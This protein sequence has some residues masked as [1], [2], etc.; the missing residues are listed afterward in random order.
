MLGA[1]VNEVDVD[2]VDLGDEVREG[3][4]AL[5][6]LSPVVIRCPIAGQRLDRLQLHA[7]GGIHFPVGPLRR[8]D[9]RTQVIELLFGDVDR[10]RADA[11]GLNGGAH[12]NLRSWWVDSALA[13]SHDPIGAVKRKQP[14]APRSTRK[15]R[16]ASGYEGARAVMRH[17]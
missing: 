14:S 7:L 5:L 16:T 3:R 11:G 6:E 13:T 4:K 10:Q 2:P 1:S 17:V 15:K 12:D 9:A 8:A